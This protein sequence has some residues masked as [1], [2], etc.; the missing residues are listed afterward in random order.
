[1]KETPNKISSHG[2]DATLWGNGPKLFVIDARNGLERK[3]LQNWLHSTLPEG[4]PGQKLNYVSLAITDQPSAQKLAALTEKLNADPET[5]VIPVRIAWRIPKFEES[6]PLRMRHLVFGDPRLPGRLRARLIL[7][8][9]K[10]RAHCLMGKPATIA[11]LQTRYAHT[12]QP[13]DGLEEAKQEHDFSSFVTRQ[14][15][16]VLD[17]AERGLR[18]SRYKVPKFVA[19]GLRAS[20]KYKRAINELSEESGQSVSELNT[21]ARTYMKELISRPNPLFIDLKAKLDRFMISQGYEGQIVCDPAEIERLREITR[22]YPTLLPFTH[23]TYLDG[24]TPT[25]L[26][27]RN[28]LPLVHVFGGINLAFFGIGTLM[29]R[30]GGIFIRRKFQ[31]NKLYKLVLRQYTSYL[32]E[33]R[34]P[35]TW[36]F[37]GTRSRLGKLM[38]PRLGLFKYIVDS[39]HSND[40]ENLHF[41]PIVTSF[42]L[43]RDVEEYATE[44]TG[45]KKK[46]ES[47]TW[48]IGYMRSLREPMGRVYVDF[49]EP[50][51]VEKAPDP[52]DSLAL[53]KIAFEVAVQ[54]N[55]VTPLTITS[56][57][58]TCLLAAAPRGM[59]TT[60]LRMALKFFVDWAAKRGIRV[61]DDLATVDF[62]RI[63][64][65][66]DTL[67][68]SKLIMRYDAGEEDVYAIEPDKHPLASYYRNSITHHFMYKA[69]IDLSLVKLREL[70]DDPDAGDLIDIFWE[71]TEHLRDLFKFEFFFP[72]K[73]QYRDAIIN[74]LNLVDTEWAAHL[75]EGGASLRRLVRRFQPYFAHAVFL[76]FIESYTVV[77]EI[78]VRLGPEDDIDKDTLVEKALQAGRQAYLLRRITSESSIGKILFENG[79]KLATNKGLTDA[80]TPDVIKERKRMLREFRELSSRMEKL[81]LQTV[82]LAKQTSD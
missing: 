68:A 65:S 73:E 35:M 56:L 20:P 49:G 27:Y 11:D 82:A 29:R 33:K 74:E 36:A 7:M 81:R 60:E 55:R 19:E 47:F 61:T 43:I 5:L 48:F 30:S 23:K 14:A 31:D 46:A 64:K 62:E 78:L 71:E 34:F 67:V 17:M 8:K 6:K 9:D 51:I 80:S 13:D 22:T 75:S 4:G 18:G 15:G 50:V 42:D 28:D 77:F 25:D 45:R 54:A 79:F 32:L 1:M 70:E 3:Y 2:P 16:L 52:N 53:S 39:A 57:M 38:P 41:V 58:C 69:I 10:R 24:M 76:P 12:S 66:V 63:R 40:I 44:Q 72:S 21:E 59:T 26:C 37:E